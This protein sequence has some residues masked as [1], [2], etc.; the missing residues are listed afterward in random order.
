[1][2]VYHEGEEPRP[3]PGLPGESQSPSARIETPQVVP[4]PPGPLGDVEHGA[5]L[6][7]LLDCPGYGFGV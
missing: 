3:H 2:R 4:P 6:D 1:M 7:E 5:H